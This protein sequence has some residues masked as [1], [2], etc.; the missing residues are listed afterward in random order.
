[1]FRRRVGRV[2]ERRE[3]EP[4]ELGGEKDQE[5]GGERTGRVGGGGYGWDVLLQCA[6]SVSGAR[7]SFSAEHALTR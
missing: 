1:M 5:E 3:N 7:P 2:V 6:K 4:L